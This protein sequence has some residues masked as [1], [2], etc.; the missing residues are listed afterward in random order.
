M[1][2]YILNLGTSWGLVVSFTSNPTSPPPKGKNLDVPLGCVG[3]PQSWSGRCD[4]EKIPPCLESIPS[5]PTRSL[6]FHF[7]SGML[8]FIGWNAKYVYKL[9]RNVILTL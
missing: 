9:L 3:V 5:R 1:A 4:E 2:P 8:K 6:V 7:S